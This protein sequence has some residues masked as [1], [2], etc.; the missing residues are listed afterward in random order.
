MVWGNFLGVITG[1]FLGA[2]ASTL[3][4]QLLQ[5]SPPDNSIPLLLGAIIVSAGIGSAWGIFSG[6]IWGGLGKF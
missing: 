3:F 4:P 6:M 5:T 2:I 1:A